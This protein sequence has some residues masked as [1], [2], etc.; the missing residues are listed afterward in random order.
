MPALARSRRV[1][2]P[3]LPGA[4]GSAEPQDADY[5]PGF[6]E[7]F[8]AAFLDAL[9][10]ERAAVVGNSLGGLAALRLALALREE[11]IV[12]KYWEKTGAA[13]VGTST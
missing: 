4:G 12:E 13:R 6:F 2:A 1:Y 11:R 10:I 8:V 7:R 5:S 3:D 9:G